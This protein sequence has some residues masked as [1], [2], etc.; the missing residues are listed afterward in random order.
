MKVNLNQPCVLS[1]ILVHL[2][3]NTAHSVGLLDGQLDR[4]RLEWPIP[5]LLSCSP[6]PPSST[7]ASRNW[8]EGEYIH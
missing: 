1:L 8:P 5:L 6:K 7:V 4:E 2:P 3:L